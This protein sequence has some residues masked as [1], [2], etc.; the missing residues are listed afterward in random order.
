MKRMIWILAVVLGLYLLL[1]FGAWLMQEMLVFPGT[2]RRS[3]TAVR[4]EDGVTVTNV[5]RADG[6]DFRIAEVMPRGEPRA[7]FLLFVGN[8]EDLTSGVY[9]AEA[10]RTA[11]IA[12]VVPE[13]PGYGTS[14]GSPTVD[15]LGEMARL[16]APRAAALAKEHDVPLLFVGSSLGDA[17]C[18]SARGGV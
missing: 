8:G 11:G 15:S 18:F 5:K 4:S 12:T 16:A 9:R 17:C 2:L 7:V 13:Y 3:S 14:G 6:E 10:F 1:C